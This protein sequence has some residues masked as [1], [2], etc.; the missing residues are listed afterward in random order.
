MNKSK[1][2]IVNNSGQDFS[3]AFDY[4]D[5]T[6]CDAQVNLTEGSQSIFDIDRMICKIKERLKDS[7]KDDYIL[8]SGSNILNVIAVG[9][10]L[11]KYREANL[12]LYN[13][14]ERRYVMRML[15]L[16]KIGAE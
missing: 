5:L 8:L 13:A 6:R 10:Q 11:Q 2:Y 12:L 1:I 14:G 16:D 4:T 7:L 9:M 3:N 15:T